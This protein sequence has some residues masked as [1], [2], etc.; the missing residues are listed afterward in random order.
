MK[1][2]LIINTAAVSGRKRARIE[3]LVCARFDDVDVAPTR[4]A[5][6][7]LRMAGEAWRLGVRRLI[8]VGGDGTIHEAANG[9]VGTN[10]ELAIV[11]AG[12]GND[13]IRTLGIPADVEA[14]V[15]RAAG[16]RVRTIDVAEV[17]FVDGNGRP[18]RR[19]F[20][21]IA[22]AGMGGDV[23][24]ISRPLRKVVGRRQGYRAGIIAGLLTM[25]WRP[26]RL[27]IDGQRAGEYL[28]TNLIVANGQYFG[29]GMR[30][31]PHARVD[32]GV[33]DVV[34]IKDLSRAG[35]AME[36][37]ALQRGL[38]REHPNVDWWTAREVRA[39]SDQRVP[40]EADGEVL[41]FLPAM[42]RVLPKSLRVVCP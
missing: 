41:G 29:G 36:A 5:G 33:L 31:V 13:F 32:D 18:G 35:V 6:D 9:V 39:E 14:A 3:E 20:V 19:V 15:E 17:R 37:K 1:V 24:R 16:S 27:W 21:N 8:V 12:S 28:M 34:L 26:L 40:I 22:E 38:P 30:P 10:V 42:F 25:R 4:E 23:A 2:G 7:V 11:P